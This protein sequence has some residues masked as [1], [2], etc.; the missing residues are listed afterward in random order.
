MSIVNE[1]SPPGGVLPL[2][3]DVENGPRS[4]PE[5]GA[6]PTPG[7]APAA[8]TPDDQSPPPADQRRDRIAQAY[9]GL[10]GSAEA[11]ERA[12]RRVHWM[13]ENALGPRVLD[14]GCSEGIL[15]ILLAREGFEV[16][17]I[18]VNAE[19][20]AYADD[21]RSRE[22]ET[23]AQR[24][25]FLVSDITRSSETL[26]PFNTV[27]LGEILEHVCQPQI[28]L[29]RAHELLRPDGRLVITTPFGYFPH[30]D[31]KQEFRASQL[32]ECV[33]KYFG[34]ESFRIRDGYAHIVAHHRDAPR[35]GTRTI[36]PDVVLREVEEVAVEL[37]KQRYALDRRLI[38]AEREKRELYKRLREAERRLDA[39]HRDYAVAVTE[40]GF[41]RRRK[42]ELEQVLKERGLLNKEKSPLKQKKG[43]ESV[44]ARA[45]RRTLKVPK[46]L[47]RRV[48]RPQAAHQPSS[49][50]PGA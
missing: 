35:E 49:G 8:V 41:A 18:D 47:L 36:E 22:H 7:D 20:I 27:F 32:I 33:S 39:R 25:R 29:E 28:L 23:T 14:I 4:A 24:L 31:H 13:A 46:K 30:P 50:A 6:Y 43:R 42:D 37:Q 45:L 1:A 38:K 3:F 40:L 10:W 11:Q 34:T 2:R 48:R 26:G 21:L 5:T 19:A 12:R 17:G 16:V 9:F 15:G 44:V